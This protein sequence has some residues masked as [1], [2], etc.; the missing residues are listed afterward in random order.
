MK[1]H[2]GTILSIVG[3]AIL[4][5]GL[6]AQTNA[7][8]LIGFVAAIAGAAIGGSR[9]ATH[10]EEDATAGTVPGVAARRRRRA[11]RSRRGHGGRG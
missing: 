4:L 6:A 9:K 8:I 7:L 1:A 2:P 11:R 5:I 10:H 3:I